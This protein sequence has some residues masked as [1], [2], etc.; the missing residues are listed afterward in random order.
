L[1]LS[2]LVSTDSSSF[3]EIV[4]LS[5]KFHCPTG[6][7]ETTQV[8]IEIELDDFVPAEFLNAVVLNNETLSISHRIADSGRVLHVDV[9]GRLRAF[10]LLQLQ[11]P[12]A[13]SHTSGRLMSVALMIEE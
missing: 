3:S 8:F 12:G 2:D 11:F 1:A 7:D 6:L 4:L 10:N 13:A 9:S 5:R